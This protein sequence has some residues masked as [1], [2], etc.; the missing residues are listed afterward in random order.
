ML[1]IAAT[2][3][4]SG[5]TIDSFLLNIAT[6]ATF[7]AIPVLI[8]AGTSFLKISIVLGMMR[9][10]IGAQ[11][12]PPSIVIYALSAVLTMF[13][14][15]PIAEESFIAVESTQN[16]SYN[17]PLSFER[18][19]VI[20]EAAAPPLINFLKVNTSDSEKAF[21]MDLTDGNADENSLRILLPAFATNEL[22]E[23][24]LIGFLI[25]LPF[26]VVDLIVSVTLAAL[27]LNM[28]SPITVSL[29]IK[30]LLLIA[31]DG[32]HVILNGLLVNYGT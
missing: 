22:V 19:K 31:A 15:A 14:M 10:A 1:C 17:E 27:G 29:P 24:F 32:W 13:V 2:A 8:A 6:T 16:S 11:D 23:A 12:V 5:L 9:S 7:I 4:A 20:Y 21:Y 3:P 30:L 18:V 28:L 25:F 26:L